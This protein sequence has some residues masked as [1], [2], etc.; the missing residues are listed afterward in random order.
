MGVASRQGDTMYRM[1]TALAATAT[2]AA[3]LIP[4]RAVAITTVSRALSNPEQLSTSA[5]TLRGK[6]TGISQGM[7]AMGQPTTTFLLC[8]AN[9]IVVHVN[10]MPN[11]MDGQYV[12][13]HN[14]PGARPGG[15][16][17]TNAI[18]VNSF[19]VY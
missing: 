3:L 8:D 9:C 7:T 11:I 15:V 17:A 16:P 13:V 12:T 1:R 6:V 5:L 10:G 19:D 4:A 14:E 2:L 18:Y